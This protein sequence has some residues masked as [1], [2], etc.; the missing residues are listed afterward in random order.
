MVGGRSQEKGE[1]NDDADDDEGDQNGQSVSHG[2]NSLISRFR[3]RQTVF[4]FFQGYVILTFSFPF[5]RRGK[6]FF[7]R[8]GKPERKR[9]FSRG[10]R[11][12]FSGCREA[13]SGWT[14]E[15]RGCPRT[16][17]RAARCPGVW[18][19]SGR[20]GPENG[21]S[22]GQGKKPGVFGGDGLETVTALPSGTGGQRPVSGSGRSG[23]HAAVSGLF[24]VIRGRQTG[25][26]P[27]ALAEVAGL[28]ES[29]FL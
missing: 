12:T 27:E 1:D 22:V 25:F 16:G 13:V 18:A 29:G 11:G 3:V 6:E 4:L 15:P 2:S 10:E 21:V 14:D 17:Q 23:R 7:C 26:F 24:P 5:F 20:R 19:V 28:S 8:V 9:F